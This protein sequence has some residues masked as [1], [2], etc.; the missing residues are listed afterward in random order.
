MDGGF[1]TLPAGKLA[2]K[3]SSTVEVCELRCPALF[4]ELLCDVHKYENL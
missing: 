3:E 2:W 1:V 4:A